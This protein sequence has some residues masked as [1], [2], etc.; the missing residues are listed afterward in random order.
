MLTLD[1]PRLEQMG[2]EIQHKR[3]AGRTVRIHAAGDFYCCTKEVTLFKELVEDEAPSNF[4]WCYSLGCKQ[5]ALV[6][7][8]DRYAD[9]HSPDPGCE[10]GVRGLS[11]G[12]VGGRRPPVAEAGAGDTEDGAQPLHAVAVVVCDELE[13]VHQRVSPAKYFAALRRISRSSSS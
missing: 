10:C 9:V 13:A 2:E 6:R 5:D 12:P 8:G 1:L 7:P 11:S 3:Y 4:R